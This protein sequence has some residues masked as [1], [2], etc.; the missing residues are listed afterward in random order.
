MKG[1]IFWPILKSAIQGGSR[2]SQLRD[3]FG[4]VVL[5]MPKLFNKTF[6]KSIADCDFK[7]ICKELQEISFEVTAHNALFL[8]TTSIRV[9]N[10]IF[11]T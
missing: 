9:G 7:K 8:D 2:L 11:L 6:A 3:L 1:G 5:F 10:A 4:N